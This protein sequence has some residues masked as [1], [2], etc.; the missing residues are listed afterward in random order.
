MTLF[1]ILTVIIGSLTACILLVQAGLALKAIKADHERRKKQATIEFVQKIRPAWLEA[2][3]KLEE[4]W[5][6]NPLTSKE[7]EEIDNDFQL[8]KVVNNLLGLLE[9]LSVGMNTGVYDK[10]LLF[11]M[12]GSFL[13]DIHNR[14]RSYI[15][16]V[17]VRNPAAYIE[18]QNLVSDFEERKRT[19][20]S[21]EGDIRHS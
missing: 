5:G 1:E 12:S 21:T 19:K 8:Q 17:Q 3:N 11:R 10:D 2:K 14:F 18:Y 4:R 7:L 9:H 20:P 16:Q 13:I 15:D 6:K